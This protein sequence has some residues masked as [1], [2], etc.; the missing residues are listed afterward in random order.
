MPPLFPRRGA[1]VVAGATR[2]DKNIATCLL[3]QAARLPPTGG[4][5]GERAREARQRRA[6]GGA[7]GPLSLWG[8]RRSP[9]P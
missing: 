8:C 2:A 9:A 4:Q 1:R 7:Q 5:H 6:L 3:L